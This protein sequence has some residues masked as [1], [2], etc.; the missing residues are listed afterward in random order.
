MQRIYETYS[1]EETFQLGEALGQEAKPG[2]VYTLTGVI[3]NFLRES[4]RTI[5]F[6]QEQSGGRNESRI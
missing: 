4:V 5:C 6:R 3:W 1:E 2:D